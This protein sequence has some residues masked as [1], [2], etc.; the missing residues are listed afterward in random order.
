MLYKLWS[1]FTKNLR[2]LLLSRADAII[3]FGRIGTF[4]RKQDLETG[5]VQFRFQPYT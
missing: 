2:H 4:V 5:M 1:G 3:K